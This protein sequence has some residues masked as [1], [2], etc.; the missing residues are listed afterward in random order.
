MLPSAFARISFPS[1]CF[2]CLDFLADARQRRGEAGPPTL[3]SAG[4][5]LVR[6]AGSPSSRCSHFPSSSPRWKD[7]GTSSFYITLGFQKK[8]KKPKEAAHGLR[9]WA[10]L[11][12]SL[13]IC[14]AGRIVCTGLLSSL[15]SLE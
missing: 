15:L 14:Q 10:S 11:A 8:K 7:S 13:A 9:K 4:H 3:T 12:I 1:A 2:L 5:G 6:A